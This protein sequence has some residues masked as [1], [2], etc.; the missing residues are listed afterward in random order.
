M[1]KQLALKQLC[2]LA[3]L[4]FCDRVPA[5]KPM[6]KR[7][8]LR[9]SPEWFGRRIVRVQMPGARTFKLAS[10]GENYLSFELFWK[11]GDYY[12][13]ITM[14]LMGQLVRDADT[15]IDVGANI[16]FYTIVTALGRPELN[17]I[18]FEPNPKNFRSLSANLE[19]NQLERVHC[20]ALALS[21]REGTA[22]LHLSPSDM[23]ASLEADFEGLR[24]PVLPVPRTTLDAYLAQ[25]PR[26]GRLVLKVDVEGH[27]PA[28]L[29]GASQTIANRK[30]DIILEVTGP[31]DRE[32]AAF[33][34]DTGYAF[35]QI[36]DQGLQ[37]ADELTLVVRGRFL[38]LNYLLSA[39]PAAE[40]AALFKCIEPR[41]RRLDLTRT[42]KCVA[43]E[44]IERL[45]DRQATALAAAA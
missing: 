34:K 33:L 31:M 18:A 15:F 20:E 37:R 38:F 1:N 6:L 44:M 8:G 4:G 42:S 41:V 2:G 25:H 11:G 24:G 10:L 36:T 21:D 32:R 43:P 26:P 22:A 7:W 14:L 39:R 45:R 23:S 9:T 27:E 28:F 30:P 19:A 40:V 3:L 17:I 13:P 16:G 29:R 12:E 5:A 35:Y